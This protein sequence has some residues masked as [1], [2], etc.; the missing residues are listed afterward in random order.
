M[1]IKVPVPTHFIIVAVLIGGCFAQRKPDTN[2]PRTVFEINRPVLREYVE[3]YYR[4]GQS[5]AERDENC[6]RI[7]KSLKHIVGIDSE[8]EFIRFTLESRFS[9]DDN[10]KIQYTPATNDNGV[11]SKLLPSSVKDLVKLENN[12]WG[13]TAP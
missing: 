11:P 6:R 4:D 1:G 7:A 2:D 3:C 9:G 5:H 8:G 10:H 13:Y 12:W